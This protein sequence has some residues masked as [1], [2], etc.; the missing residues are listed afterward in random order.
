MN[1]HVN[2]EQYTGH[3][4]NQATKHCIVCVSLAVEI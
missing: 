4:G 1:A 2:K 3:N